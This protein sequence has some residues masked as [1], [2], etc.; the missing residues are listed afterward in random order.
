M[1]DEWK[2][3]YLLFDFELRI[4]YIDEAL[5]GNLVFLVQ[6]AM[7][8]TY[9][10]K[11]QALKFYSSLEFLVPVKMVPQWVVV[12]RTM[13]CDPKVMSRAIYY[14]PDNIAGAISKGD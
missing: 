13:I 8:S 7:T 4:T 3:E 6:Q 9:Q 2:N 11:F 12:L 10:N 5:S 1:K 14:G